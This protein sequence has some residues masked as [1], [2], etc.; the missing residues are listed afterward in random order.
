MTQG[1]AYD[2]SGFVVAAGS[3]IATTVNGSTANDLIKVGDTPETVDG[4]AGRDT[5]QFAGNLAAHAVSAGPG[6]K[7]LVDDD[8]FINVEQFRFA[9]STYRWDGTQMVDL[10][11]HFGNGKDVVDGTVLDDVLHGERGADTLYGLDGDDRLYGGQGA[12][13]LYGGGDRDFLSGG[14]GDDYLSGGDGDDLLHGG[15]GDDELFGGNGGDIFEFGA[16]SGGNDTIGDFDV[17][18]DK[19]HL[20][21]GL[22]IAG[23]SEANGSTTL[24]LSNGG[25]VV[26][27]NVTGVV[28]FGPLLTANLPPLWADVQF[29]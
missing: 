15:K 6:G 24:A 13:W 18:A 29:G 8:S 17:S 1:I 26:L 28:D 27:A 10:T 14:Q 20:S 12:D 23:A 4:A 11:Q 7:V 5:A 9:D 19:L 25:S 3:V 21:D 16:F 2:A 22:T